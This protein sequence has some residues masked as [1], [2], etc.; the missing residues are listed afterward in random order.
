MP[1]SK[2]SLRFP[3]PPALR[4]RTVKMLARLDGDA[5]PTRH[6]DDLCALVLTLTESGMDH[7]FL[8]AVADAKLGFVARQ[9]ASLGVAGAVRVMAPIVR[10]VLGGADAAQL[11]AV[12]QHIRGLMA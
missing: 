2:T 9:T 1:A 5:D 11:R 3:L 7:Y 4:A 6:T 10:S 8:K 12:S